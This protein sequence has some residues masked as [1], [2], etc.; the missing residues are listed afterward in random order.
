MAGIRSDREVRHSLENPHGKNR[1]I[2]DRAMAHIRSVPYTVS[3]RWLFYRL[4][5]DGLYR[6]KDDYKRAVDIFARARLSFYGDWNPGTLA[7]E[8]RAAEVRGEGDATPEQ[9]LAAVTRGLTIQLDRWQTQPRYVE[10]WFE[11]AAMHGQFRHYVNENITLM[12]FKG[13]ASIPLKNDTAIRL[14][15]RGAELDKEIVILYFGDDDPKGWQIP[16]SAWADIEDWAGSDIEFVRV[17]LNHGD[18]QRLGIPEN[19]DHPGCYQ[20]EALDD[21][22]ASKLIGQV[23]DYLDLDAFAECEHVE[24]EA[25]SKVKAKLQEVEF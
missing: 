7:D 24:E 20:W 11:A 16:E 23:D 9:W 18:G 8:G 14:K 10:V 17:G 22:N 5:Q 12:P 4:L 25:A 6:G 1:V 21:D 19:P 3:L 2:L 15:E 13:D